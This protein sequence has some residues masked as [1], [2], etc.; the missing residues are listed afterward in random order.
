ML[1]IQR[2]TIWKCW[3]RVFLFSTCC[4]KLAMLHPKSWFNC[5]VGNQLLISGYICYTVSC[6]RKSVTNKGSPFHSA[7]ILVTGTKHGPWSHQHPTRRRIVPPMGRP[8]PDVI[9]WV[10]TVHLMC[11]STCGIDSWKR[12]KHQKWTWRSASPPILFV[13][14]KT[15]ETRL[16]RR[17]QKPKR[18]VAWEHQNP[19]SSWFKSCGK[20][21]VLQS[22][23]GNAGPTLA[24][25]NTR[26][27]SGSWALRWRTAGFC[28][29]V[30]PEK[31]PK[32]WPAKGGDAVEKRPH[33]LG[34]VSVITFNNLISQQLPT[35]LSWD[36]LQWG[37]AQKERRYQHVRRQNYANITHRQ[38]MATS[39][40]YI[41]NHS[42]SRAARK[43]NLFPPY[44]RQS[45]I[46]FAQDDTVNQCP[47]HSSRCWNHVAFWVIFYCRWWRSGE[48][49]GFSDCKA[50]Q[51]EMQTALL[52]KGELPTFSVCSM[53]YKTLQHHFADGTTSG[54]TVSWKLSQCLT[55]ARSTR[56]L[57]WS[58][59]A[60]SENR[61]E[62]ANQ[63]KRLEIRVLPALSNLIEFYA[64]L[65][66][67]NMVEPAKQ[68]PSW[69]APMARIPATRTTPSSIQD[70]D[71]VEVFEQKIRGTLYMV[72]AENV[73]IR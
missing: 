10:T 21:Q 33:V 26:R 23:S 51:T 14:G 36:S 2:C 53:A 59:L 24:S 39:L 49:Q 43:W 50:M 25:S 64:T 54:P 55:A 22:Q 40:Q 69:G 44:P 52:E 70:D 16:Q 37:R 42:M 63:I 7:D 15:Y 27:P 30:T 31:L 9:C 65:H 73:K 8:R 56:Q 46:S 18:T 17:K 45:R 60:A 57:E 12:P 11:K 1:R 20:T 5:R 48:T 35:R 67:C 34:G 4:E 13:S 61:A 41:G 28:F 3:G 32:P 47:T 72:K 6:T 62:W 38:N 19:D 71:H 66:L 68:F 29:R 58:S